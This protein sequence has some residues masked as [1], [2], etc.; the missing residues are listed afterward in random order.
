MDVV[1]R[2][3]GVKT[4]QENASAPQSM[5]AI[6]VGLKFGKWEYFPGICHCCGAVDMHLRAIGDKVVSIEYIFWRPW[7]LCRCQLGL[8]SPCSVGLFFLNGYNT[9]P[10]TITS[11]EP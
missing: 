9:L 11:V 7:P 10:S 1:E 8:P 5:V 6:L 3:A 2:I 4:V